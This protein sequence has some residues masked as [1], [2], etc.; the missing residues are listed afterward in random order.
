MNIIRAIGLYIILMG[1]T[2]FL[3]FV[4]GRYVVQ[5]IATIGNAT[6]IAEARQVAQNA[7]N[8]TNLFFI[9]L[10]ILWTL[11]IAYVAHS[12]EYEVSYVQQ[13]R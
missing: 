2:V 7:V 8:G 3:W 4:L 5:I 12:Q 6:D 10:L 11:W 13:R 9:F 1:I